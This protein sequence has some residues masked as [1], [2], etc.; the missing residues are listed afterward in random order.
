M[1]SWFNN[2]VTCMNDSRRG[3]GLD[4]GFIDNLQFVTTNNYNSVANFHT[5]Q[6]TRAHAMFCSPQC[7]H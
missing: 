2:I 4:I 6:F 7:L 5:L 1:N 3:F